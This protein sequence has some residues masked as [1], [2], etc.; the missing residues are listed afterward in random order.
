MSDCIFPFPSAPQFTSLTSICKYMN[1]CGFDFTWQSFHRIYQSYVKTRKTTV[2]KMLKEHGFKDDKPETIDKLSM[3]IVRNVLLV[4]LR[5]ILRAS[6]KESGLLNRSQFVASLRRIAYRYDPENAIELMKQHVDNVLKAISDS[7][8][9]NKGGESNQRY[10]N[11]LYRSA[12]KVSGPSI[13]ICRKPEQWFVALESQHELNIDI[14]APRVARSYVRIF[15]S[16]ADVLAEEE[17]D[18]EVAKAIRGELRATLMDFGFSSK[19]EKKVYRTCAEI[20]EH[21][22]DGFIVDPEGFGNYC[23]DF[24]H[25]AIV[26]LAKI[27]V[28]DHMAHLAVI[29]HHI[30]YFLSDIFCIPIAKFDQKRIVFA[31]SVATYF[32]Q[33]SEPQSSIGMA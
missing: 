17:P 29:D 21:M 11:G 30:A 7:L 22:D 2:R 24:V 9:G 12:I 1:D 13:Q 31:K 18:L 10:L 27:S 26:G 19:D 25:E 15:T 6:I 14:I 23:Y 28:K 32:G 5:T 4:D 16:F 33:G 3:F 8:D 20:L